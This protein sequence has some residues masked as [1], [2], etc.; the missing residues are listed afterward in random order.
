MRPLVLAL[1]LVAS[2]AFAADQI[3]ERAPGLWQSTSTGPDGMTT[4]KQCVGKGT[5]AAAMAAMGMQNCAKKEVTKT[6]EGYSTETECKVGPVTAVAKGVITGDF[7]TV[8]RTETESTVT[9]LP[10]Q[11]APAPRKMVIEAKRLGD[12]EPGQSPG[13]IVMPDGKVIKTPG[14]K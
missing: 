2:P 13:D 4:V 3:P 7:T 6:A 12:C 10:N 9:G 14:S 5:D 11:S 1:V 8:V